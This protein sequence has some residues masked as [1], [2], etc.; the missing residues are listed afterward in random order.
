LVTI[1]RS[2]TRSGQNQALKKLHFFS[3]FVTKLNGLALIFAAVLVVILNT[4]PIYQAQNIAFRAR[5]KSMREH[6]ES[7]AQMLGW[8]ERLSIE[9]MPLL[10]RF[11][12]LPAERLIVLDENGQVIY[13]SV[14]SDS[15]IHTRMLSS[16][17]AAA[18]RGN[19]HFSYQYRETDFYSQITMPV[20]YKDTITGVVF[21]SYLDSE[22]GTQLQSVRH[23]FAVISCFVILLFA[24]F[25]VP[26]S[27]HFARQMKI[28]RNTF[29]MMAKGNYLIRLDE[30]GFDEFATLRQ[31]LNRLNI[32]LANTEEMRRRFVSDASHELKTPLASVKLLSDSILQTPDMRQEDIHEF[33]TDIN[34]EIDRLTRI[35]GRLLQISTLE[36]KTLQQSYRRTDAKAVAENVCRMLTSLAK[37]SQC[38][39]R[40]EL[41]EDCFVRASFDILYQIFYN[42]VENS[43]KYSGHNKEVR[44]FLY[45]REEKV[46]FIVDDD[47]EGIPESDLERIFD[48]FYR[49]DK[50]RA[51]S[52][53]GTGLGLSIVA[54][55]VQNCGGTVKAENRSSGGARFTVIFPLAPA[56]EEGGEFDG[57]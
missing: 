18:I 48:R 34:N 16:E 22:L 5:E 31:E 3:A 32:A 26:L 53:G 8:L 15:R 20:R 25:T 38:T 45:T 42:L 39:I 1:T 47:G 14:T 23:T 17:T 9:E 41:A 35:S 57:D 27:I 12:P 44:I 13:D 43:I 37:A 4:V 54:T 40:P 56:E 21:L 24:G 28:I 30:T 19:V 50:A 52:T 10:A 29:S 51:R 6:A 33:L 7:I 11:A 36:D 2:D 46:Y 55:A 49:V